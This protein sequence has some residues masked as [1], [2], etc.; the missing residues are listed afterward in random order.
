[1]QE[2]K[3]LSRE[4]HKTATE[5]ISIPEKAAIT[6]IPE[7]SEVVYPKV[8]LGSFLS[9]AINFIPS[10][11]QYNSKRSK[12]GIQEGDI[13][14]GKMEDET[15]HTKDEFAKVVLEII[16]KSRTDIG[17]NNKWTSLIL[18]CSRFQ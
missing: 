16:S 4:I 9:N 2:E 7:L 8:F 15:S 6:Q 3:S 13:D 10:D 17:R 18:I 12:Q 11:S 5:L 14:D 1:M